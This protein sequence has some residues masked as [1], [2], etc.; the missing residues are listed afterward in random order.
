MSAGVSDTELTED[1]RRI[2]RT[3][4]KTGRRF[5]SLRGGAESAWEIFGSKKWT[6]VKT[7]SIEAV[8]RDDLVWRSCELTPVKALSYKN[9]GEFDL[10]TKKNEVI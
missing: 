3:W 8:N 6:P 9:V 5:S 7:F 2:S 1:Q 10:A 4:R